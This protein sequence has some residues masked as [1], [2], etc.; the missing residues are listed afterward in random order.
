MWLWLIIF[1]PVGLVFLWVQRSLN[2]VKKIILTIIAGV[3]FLV[4]LFI[5][6]M[7]IWNPIIP[8]YD[9]HDEFVEVFNQEIQE[10]NLP[11]NLQVTEEKQH[12]ITSELG[13]DITL[14]ENIDKDGNVQE[15]I[16]I[17]QGTGTDIVLTI[18][19]LIGATNSELVKQDIGQVLEE[20]RFFDENYQFNTSELTVEK[21]LIRY[22]LKYDQAIGIIFSVSKV[23]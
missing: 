6:V 2:K 17:G 1:P 7:I 5:F 13:Q 9:S 16:L 22:H 8:L 21:N 19:L 10:Q 12:L 18:G 4:F 23:N 14:L 11:Y 3:Y 15:L 20:L